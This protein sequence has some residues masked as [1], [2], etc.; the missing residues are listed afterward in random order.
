[1]SLQIGTQQYS[2]F[3]VSH[4]GRIRGKYG[5]RIY[6]TYSDGKTKEQMRSG[7]VSKREAQRT[8]D[9]TVAL[10][11]SHEYVTEK[12][13][14]TGD[15]LIAWLEQVKKTD[16]RYNSYKSYANAIRHISRHI[17]KIRISD[18][19]RSHIMELYKKVCG[20]SRAVAENVKAIM[21]MALDD[22]SKMGYVAVNIALDVS[23]PPVQK[24]EKA[25]AT[26]IFSVEQLVVL[27]HAAEE[28]SIRTQV[29]FAALLGLRIGEINGLKY[30]DIDFARKVLW[31]RRQ[32]GKVMIEG[33]TDIA[34]KQEL[35]PKTAAGYRCMDLPQIILEMIVAQRS[36]YESDRR[37]YGAGFN[38]VD[39]IVC[40]RKGEPRSRGYH[41]GIYKK[42]LQ[43][44]GLPHIS[45]HGLRRTYA[46]LLLKNDANMKTVAN[47]L[48][49]ASADTT[50]DH[51]GE[52]SGIVDGYAEYIEAYVENVL[53]GH[54]IEEHN[55]L[56]V[57]DIEAF[58]TEL[59]LDELGE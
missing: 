26:R 23:L 50:I 7:F 8:R 17:G 5:F 42:L 20:T 51:Y 3:R 38:D 22:A 39:Y 41:A 59:S 49:H 21:S 1:M 18:L 33:E 37:K 12:H 24:M 13:V 52:M 53:P 46:T 6:L 56:R 28:T 47:A 35:P 43:S 2:D 32:M 4:V 10:L 27:L 16:L 45:F 36:T 25:R 19:Q 34:S 58:I 14:K 29:Y 30:E 55:S 11:A 31:V 40:S 9:K 54:R 48:G 57:K 15:Y 44:C